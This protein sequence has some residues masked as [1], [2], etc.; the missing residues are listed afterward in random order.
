MFEYVLCHRVCNSAQKVDVSFY[1]VQSV[2][3]LLRS[4][5]IH[6]ISMSSVCCST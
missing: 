4:E 5:A 1:V 2:L 6:N 3:F